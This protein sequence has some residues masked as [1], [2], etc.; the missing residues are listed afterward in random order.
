[1]YFSEQWR[2]ALRATPPT[3]PLAAHPLAA[4]RT[5]HVLFT[6]SFVRTTLRSKSF[7][8]LCTVMSRKLVPLSDPS[9]RTERMLMLIDY[10]RTADGH[11]LVPPTVRISGTQYTWQ[12]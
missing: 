10:E 5:A 8:K 2:S 3:H 4:R 7:V 9:S 1:M 12:H 11:V 6:E